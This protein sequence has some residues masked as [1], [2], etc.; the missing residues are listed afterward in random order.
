[1]TGSTPLFVFEGKQDAP[2]SRDLP[3]KPL[4]VRSLAGLAS[5]H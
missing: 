4:P 2:E 3:Q 5:E 1:M